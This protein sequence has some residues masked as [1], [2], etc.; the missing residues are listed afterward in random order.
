MLM[1]LGLLLILA[2]AVVFGWLAE[3]TGLRPVVSDTRLVPPAVADGPYRVEANVT[4]DGRGHGEVAVTIKIR[5]QASGQSFQTDRKL[6]LDS[7]ETTHII[8]DIPAPPAAYTPTVEAVY[9]PR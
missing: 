7:H 9:P 6:D 2:L 1:R 5:D 8:A 3:C 4:N